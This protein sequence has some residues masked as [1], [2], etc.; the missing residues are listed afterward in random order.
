[1][2]NLRVLRYLTQV[3]KVDDAAKNAWYRHWVESGLLSLEQ[4][5]VASPMTG[6]FCHGESPTLADLTL[7]PQIFNGQRFDCD[8]SGT[9]TVM[10]IF[11]A[12]MDVDAFRRA[13]PSAQPDAE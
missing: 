5:L 11:D 10:R 9:P 6:T 12:C 3:L 13:V 2:N 7:V 8:F 4:Q 1:M